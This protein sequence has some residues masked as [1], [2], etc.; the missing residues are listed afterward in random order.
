VVLEHALLPVRPS[1]G[2]ASE[3]ATAIVA[4]SPGPVDG[5]AAHER[6]RELRHRSDD[7]FP[8]VGHVDPVLRV[9][10]VARTA[11]PAGRGAAGGRMQ[12]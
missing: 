7:P 4:A 6:W 2:A 3:A 9:S 8:L 11:A 1:R 5:S 10:R 12:G